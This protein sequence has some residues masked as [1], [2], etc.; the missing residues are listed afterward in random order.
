MMIKTIKKLFANTA[1]TNFSDKS[2]SEQLIDV[3]EQV[4]KLKDKK[5]DLARYK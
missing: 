1:E 2:L 5:I 4:E 3:R